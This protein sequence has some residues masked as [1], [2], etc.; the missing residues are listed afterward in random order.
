MHFEIHY[1]WNRMTY[2]ILCFG[3]K[4]E[5]VSPRE[6]LLDS[7]SL[8]LESVGDVGNGGCSESSSCWEFPSTSGGT[9]FSG[10]WMRYG[11][12]LNEELLHNEDLDT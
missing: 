4:A 12:T 11:T 1:T 3:A 7:E 5:V 9:L 10:S 2:V 8:K 6:F